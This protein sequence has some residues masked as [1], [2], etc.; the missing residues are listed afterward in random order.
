MPQSKL[1]FDVRNYI[2]ILVTT[3]SFLCSIYFFIYLA[4]LGGMWDPLPWPEI[5]PCTRDSESQQLD[6]WG[7]PQETLSN[8]LW[9]PQLLL[10]AA[11]RTDKFLKKLSMVI[12]YVPGCRSLDHGWKAPGPKVMPPTPLTFPPQPV[13]GH[14]GAKDTCC[15]STIITTSMNSFC[16]LS[17]LSTATFLGPI[18]CLYQATVLSELWPH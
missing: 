15:F 4:A 9:A 17:T 12:G 5:K 16:G 8:K 6:E 13:W 14:R 3:N 2:K 18:T 7:S 11:A 1:Q 10:L